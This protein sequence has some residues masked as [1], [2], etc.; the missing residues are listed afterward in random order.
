MT[1]A[2]RGAESAQIVV[3]NHHLYFADLALRQ[4]GAGGVLPEHDAVIFDE[5]HQLEDVATS[6]FGVQVS[7]TRLVRLCRDARRSL[8]ARRD[9]QVSRLL[10]HIQRCS[11]EFFT[12]LRGSP[13]GGRQ[14]LEPEAF[15]AELS[16]RM[17]AL[18]NA[19][20]ALANHARARPPD[21][22]ILQLARRA[23]S[24]REDLA[25]IAEGRDRAR[26]SWTQSRGKDSFIGSSPVDVSELLREALFYRTPAIVLTSAT[27]G[28]AGSFE[29]VERR[30]GIESELEPIEKIVPSP[31]DYREQVALYVAGHLPDPRSE[32]YFEAAFGELRG[33]LE[34]LGGGALVLCTS[35][36]AMRRFHA[37]A[38]REPAGALVAGPILMQGEAPKGKLLERFR[39]A[40]DALLFATASFWEGVDVP[41]DAL[42]LVVMDKLPFDVPS[43]PVIAAR[44]QRLEAEGERSFMKYL[45]PAAALALKQGFGRLVRTRK[46]RGVVAILDSRI[47]HRGYGKVFLRSLPEAQ[48]C[49]SLEQVRRFWS[50]MQAPAGAP[51]RGE[52][53]P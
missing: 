15:T 36:R 5:A 27:L 26:V 17:H 48:R 9:P 41:G 21:D 7:T 22:R 52:V 1:R 11:G 40:G 42:R 23:E 37:R 8:D 38:L 14:A 32:A 45:V 13:E 18:D 31:F 10:E 6:F 49:E 3:V 46:D 30:L 47:A 39:A 51:E 43:D 25:T 28:A 2:R 16:E 19:L 34:V 24:V 50:A 53:F 12:G 29:F 33:L 20:D 35:L 44:C 4:G